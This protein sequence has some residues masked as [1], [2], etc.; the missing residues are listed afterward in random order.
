MR[1][2]LF[3]SDTFAVEKTDYPSYLGSADNDK[4]KESIIDSEHPEITVGKG[5]VDI[6]NKLD[7]YS[8]SAPPIL[9]HFYLNGNEIDLNAGYIEDSL[10]KRSN[11]RLVFSSAIN[12]KSLNI[13]NAYNIVWESD[14]VVNAKVYLLNYNNLYINY[15]DISNTFSTKLHF[16]VINLKDD[17]NNLKI[18]CTE[19]SKI[20]LSWDPIEDTQNYNMINVYGKFKFAFEN[21]DVLLKQ[22]PID[23]TEITLKTKREYNSYFIRLTNDEEEEEDIYEPVFEECPLREDVEPDDD[24]IEIE[25]ETPPTDLITALQIINQINEVEPLRSKE[26]CYD[27]T[28]DGEINIQDFINVYNTY[29]DDL[30]SESYLGN[31]EFIIE[32]SVLYV[33]TDFPISAIEIYF[34]AAGKSI[35]EPQSG[36]DDMEHFIHQKYNGDYQL[37]AYSFNGGKVPV[38]K[39]PLLK[40]NGDA[41]LKNGLLCDKNGNAITLTECKIIIHTEPTDKSITNL[42]YYNIVGK[43]ISPDVIG[44]YPDIYIQAVERDGKLE[45]STKFKI[46]KR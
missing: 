31:A 13:M 27:F 23:E 39:Q 15:L 32:D 43:E 14:T 21:N 24:V 29:R 44:R 16:Y 4:V 20:K 38:G 41:I 6:S 46:I 45:E 2:S 40:F 17:D 28:Y 5:I 18:E 7:N 3:Y 1:K 25:C 12:K 35:F 19:G 34:E 11:I 42:H 9:S 10:S 22:I 37:L 30:D 33:S 36:L 26:S 8:I